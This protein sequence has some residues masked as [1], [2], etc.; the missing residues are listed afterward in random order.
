MS[1]LVFALLSIDPANF[2]TGLSD[3]TAKDRFVQEALNGAIDND[4]KLR[5]QAHKSTGS[6]AC[7]LLDPFWPGPGEDG[8]SEAQPT[9]EQ[10]GNFLEGAG[11]PD[12]RS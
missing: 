3:Q 12:L 5:R 6:P 2:S 7:N 9:F 11:R 8:F 4:R 1:E 10:V